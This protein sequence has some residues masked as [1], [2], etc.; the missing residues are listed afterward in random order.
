MALVLIT[1]RAFSIGLLFI[2]LRIFVCV[3]VGGGYGSLCGSLP[4]RIDNE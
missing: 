1:W 4:R 3:A 2:V